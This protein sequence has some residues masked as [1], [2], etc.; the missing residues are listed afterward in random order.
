MT[1]H[2]DYN[3][4]A[5]LKTFLERSGLAMQKKF[6]QNFLVNESARKRLVDALEISNGT[7]VW[8]VGPGLGC[9][10]SELL[11][12]GAEVVA[13]EI[14]HGFARLL[15]DFF[16]EFNERGS[17]RL[18]E[19]DVLKTWPDY[20]DKNGAPERFFGNLPYNVAGTLIADT[21]TKGLRFDRAVFTVQKEVGQRMT[22]RPGTDDYSSLSVLCQWA[23]NV[24]PVM[25]LAPGNFWPA[26]KVM[27][28][29]VLLTKKDDFPCCNNP[30]FFMAMTR[31]IFS[32]RRK[33]LR[34][35]LLRLAPP[36]IC[37]AALENAN[38]NP[39]IR[40][41]TLGIKALLELSDALDSAIMQEKIKCQR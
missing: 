8:E 36:E 4:P 29:A 15:T 19:G 7:K 6:G 12:R 22:A 41:E 33:T 39:A 10:T 20:A 31:Q 37:D 27:S 13:F 23:Y 26:P 24:K 14:D 17:F 35:N 2:P 32:L 9:M 16:D 1:E 38:I 25:D 30:A 18:V 40:A 5:A 11:G 21:I 3:S 34:N 28:R